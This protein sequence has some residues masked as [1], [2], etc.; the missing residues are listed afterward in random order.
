MK[1]LSIDKGC[2]KYV[3]DFQLAPIITEY[4]LW[5]SANGD[6]VSKRK[7]APQFCHRNWDSYTLRSLISSLLAKPLV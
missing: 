1:V 3:K 6:A 5:S 4:R 7:R 2:L